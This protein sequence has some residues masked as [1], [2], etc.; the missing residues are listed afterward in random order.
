M[1]ALLMSVSAWVGT[2]VPARSYL[3][4]CMASSI[5]AGSAVPEPKAVL[6]SFSRSGAAGGTRD[7][8]SD[9]ATTRKIK[10]C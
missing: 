9:I 5:D 4:R 3:S 6:K 1:P 10:R 2:G 7:P 8:F